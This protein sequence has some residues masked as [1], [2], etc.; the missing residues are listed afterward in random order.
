MPSRKEKVLFCWSGGKDSALALNRILRSGYE[1]VAL[2]TTFNA[3]YQR[4]SM[5]GIRET[6]LEKQVDAIGL[7]LEKVHVSQRSSNEEYTEKMGAVM[8]R[9]KAQGIEQVVF[10]DIFL[11]DLKRWR[12]A[13][14]AQVGMKALFPIWKVDT[15]EL[16]QEFLAFGFRS[17]I[18]CVNDAYFGE[19]TVGKEIDK[20]FVANLPANVDPCGEN[21]E[22][23]S[24]A[25]AGPIFRKPLQIQVGE[26]VYR[27]VEQTHPGST[28]CPC[29]APPDPARPQT[30]G[31]WFCDLD[32][33]EVA[34]AACRT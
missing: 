29:P 21:G 2:L 16:L 18:C 25:W 3:H 5:H 1:V 24:F 7:P 8:K 13:N 15:R 33:V 14:L 32:S 34:E 10:G 23:H 11:E 17:I 31:F 26:K 9:Y 4:V 19:E 22:Y 30:K 27:P 28:P 12:E 20:Q 6:L